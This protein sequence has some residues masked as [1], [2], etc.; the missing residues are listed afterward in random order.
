MTL[1][2]P[3]HAVELKASAISDEITAER[4]Y[5]TISSL[6]DLTANDGHLAGYQR[7][8]PALGIPI[9]RLGKR[10]TLV[11][12]PDNPR[13]EQKPGGKQRFI[14]YEYP[15]GIPLCFDVLPRYRDALQKPETPVWFTEGAKKADALASLGEELVPISLNGVWCWRSKDANGKSKPLPDFHKVAWQGRRVYL[16]FDSD[17][18]ANPNV[19]QAL[20]SLA[21]TLDKRG[22]QVYI[23]TLPSLADGTKQG[24]DDVLATGWTFEDLL[25]AATPYKRCQ[26]HLSVVAE[27]SVPAGPTSDDPRPVIDVTSLDI[28]IVAG[29]VW[30]AIITANNPPT[31]FRR[32]DDMVRLNHT[33]RGSLR[34]TVVDDARMAGIIARAARILRTDSHGDTRGVAPP[35]A[36]VDDCL[37]NVDP[38]LPIITRIV[39]APTLGPDLTVIQFSGYHARARLYYDPRSG[40]EVPSVPEQ[41]TPADIHNARALILDDL[42]VDFPFTSDAD[43]AHAVA[44]FLLPFVREL[45]A[46]PTPLHLIEAPVMGSGKSLLA[47]VLLLPALGESP[48]PFR[49]C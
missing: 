17:Y 19:K 32:G 28:P 49:A 11:I 37:V 18:E 25:K 48:A 45:I 35:S 7:R 1:L 38:R 30:D 24:V 42:L 16:A 29:A 26:M 9:Y 43:R 13:V 10:Y 33:E 44:L 27:R 12:K 47:E 2:S 20:R 21:D 22:A 23:V 14:K 34:L 46:G 5:C 3:Q 36:L 40:L 4:G 41:P 39:T 6:E 8:V 31:L 15:E